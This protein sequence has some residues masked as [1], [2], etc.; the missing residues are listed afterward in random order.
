MK[1]TD[2][3]ENSMC[4]LMEVTDEGSLSVSAM[5]NLSDQLD[6]EVADRSLDLLNGI[7]LTLQNGYELT[8]G[9]GRTARLLAEAT[10]FEEDS[11]MHEF[12]DEEPILDALA[13]ATSL[14]SRRG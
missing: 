11:K 3:P 5:Q 14:K 8:E 13:E 12:E 1:Y 6:E 7:N 9:F 2:L 4:I 10:Y